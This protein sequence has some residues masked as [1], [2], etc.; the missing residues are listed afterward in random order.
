[1]AG[2]SAKF[3]NDNKNTP[4]S[5]SKPTAL[6]VEELLNRIKTP[7]SPLGIIENIKFV[8]NHD[9]LLQEQFYGKETL[10]NVFGG[11]DIDSREPYGD[12]SKRVFRLYILG[13]EKMYPSL[14]SASFGIDRTYRENTIVSGWIRLR[15]SPSEVLVFENLVK[16][17]GAPAKIGPDYQRTPAH[18]QTVFLPSTH[19]FGRQLMTY[20]D[21]TA[22]KKRSISI[23]LNH[24]GSL[25]SA[26]FKVE[27]RE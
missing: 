9:L 21:Q 3:V 26:G 22:D 2:P 12:S 13:L 17:F 24:Q 1:M 16:I 4:F 23:T 5:V 19:R 7:T 11:H 14:S 25:E 15:F 6:S 8:L 18:G 20:V 10:L 27:P